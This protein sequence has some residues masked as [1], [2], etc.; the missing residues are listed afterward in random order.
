MD[1][2]AEAGPRIDERAGVPRLP[3]PV[4]WLL[5]R[6][7]LPDGR[8]DMDVALAGD[9]I[10]ACAPRLNCVAGHTLDLAGRLLSPAFVESHLHLDAVLMN[11]GPEAGRPEPYESLAGLNAA[12]ERRRR[13]FTRA[14]IEE[15]AGR[16][17]ELALSHGVTAIRAQCQI[18]PEIGLKHLEA[19]VAVRERYA[20]SLTL[21]IVAFPQQGLLRLPGTLDLFRAALRGGADVMGC[22]PN[23]ERGA[24]DFRRH[25]DAAYALALEAG[26]DVDAHVDLV[27]A[28]EAGLDDLE[29]VHLARRALD[30]GYQGRVVAGHV[31]T[32]D[33][34]APDTAALA[35]ALLAQAGV[36]VISQPDLYR[37]GRED[38]QHVRRGLTRVKALLAAGVNVALASNNVRDAF[39]PLGNFD[40]L[41]EALILAFG[42]HMDTVDELAALLRMTTTHPARALRLPAYGLTPGDVAD[43]VVLDAPTASAAVGGQV[44]KRYVFQRGRLVATNQ[45]LR[46]RLS[47][48]LLQRQ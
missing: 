27:L 14:D 12:M 47:G 31:C 8:T 3:Q 43:L 29:V 23:L 35:C 17:V 18:D 37:L 46:E 2:I 20:D 42:A 21:Q 39:R 30:Y 25:I 48:P 22:A 44:D 32:L 11:E 9:R 38:R 4:D 33:S 13:A 5:Q 15:R 16:A 7:N 26:V 40:L 28:D 10:V 41:Q 45:T 19:L 1:V 36:S 34:A 6:A 24:V